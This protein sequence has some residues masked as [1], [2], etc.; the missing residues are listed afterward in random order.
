MVVLTLLL[1]LAVFA[2]LSSAFLSDAQA[3]DPI[4]LGASVPM[5]PSDDGTSRRVLAGTRAYV[6][7]V[8]A[9]GG[10]S[11]RPL[12]LVA[13]D[14]GNDPARD[15]RNVR[16]LVTE[17]KAVAIV[18]CIGDASCS[19]AA[20]AAAELRVPLIG[21]MAPLM[22]FTPAS[23]PLVFRVRVPF[24]KEATAI[25]RQ[26]VTLAAFRVAVLTENPKDSD[27]VAALRDAL[28]REG[29]TATVLTVDRSRKDS[30]EAMLGSLRRGRFQALILDI[31]RESMEMI[32][33]SGL[34]QRDEWP[35]VLVAT[36]SGGVQSLLGS[37]KGRILGFPT[38]VPDPEAGSVPFVREFQADAA[39]FGDASAV[40]Y[41]GLEAYINARVA[42]EALRRA[43]PNLQAERLAAALNG[44]VSLDLAGMP[45]SF[46]PGRASASDFIEWVV[47]SRHGVIL[48]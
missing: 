26:L 44:M 30:F 29:A 10:V 23:N 2:L 9:R 42:G 38:V 43:G 16:A 32:V 25:A 46:R 6:E 33:G 19:A 12:R 20:A 45:L 1:R 3:S 8:N 24:E 47:R 34:E 39:K 4:V 41:A 13:L 15:A 11:G 31:G 35:L 17:G 36:A 27:V 40:T 7:A 5:G 18:S 22:G 48:K 21:P 14:N 37:F 28:T